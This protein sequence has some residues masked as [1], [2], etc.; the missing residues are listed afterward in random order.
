MRAFGKGVWGELADRLF[1]GCVVVGGFVAFL[2]RSHFSWNKIVDGQWETIA[3]LVSSVSLMVIWHAFRSAHAVSVEI[4]GERPVYGFT[5][6]PQPQ[7]LRFPRA[8]LYG[9]AL[10][11]TALALTASGLL[12]TI[13]IQRSASASIASGPRVKLLEDSQQMEEALDSCLLD[14][15]KQVHELP[16]Q[17]ENSNKLVGRTGENAQQYKVAKETAAYDQLRR[18]Y[19]ETYAEKAKTLRGQ[20]MREVPGVSKP[21][22]SYDN[23]YNA[24]ALNGIYFDFK[25]LVEAY[26]NK[27]ASETKPKQP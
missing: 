17:I 8:K 18:T 2:L 26:R 19:Q 15:V 27:L 20:L 7:R 21:D 4:A 10:C 12:W 24:G 1:E 13:S 9:I 16:A 25:E 22:I 5:D 6:Q 14:W 3:I 23:P 11:M